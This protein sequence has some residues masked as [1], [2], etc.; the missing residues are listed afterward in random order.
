MT[1]KSTLIALAGA[2]TYAL[3]LGVCMLLGYL[4][5][6]LSAPGV[7]STFPAAPLFTPG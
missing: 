6:V 2:T 5:L 3:M 4:V 7:I 1:L